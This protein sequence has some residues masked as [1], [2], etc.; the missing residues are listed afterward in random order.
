MFMY[1][2]DCLLW[3]PQVGS[4]VLDQGGCERSSLRTEAAGHSDAAEIGEFDISVPPSLAL[5]G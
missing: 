3:C 2:Q 4:P 1:S 5:P